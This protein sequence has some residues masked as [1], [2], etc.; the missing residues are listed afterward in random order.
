MAQYGRRGS[1]SRSVSAPALRVN[2]GSYSRGRSRES[3]VDYEK[4]KD[5]VSH[6]IGAWSFQEVGLCSRCRDNRE[7]EIL[8]LLSMICVSDL[9]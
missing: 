3:E 9:I 4:G 7:K 1:R 6:W 8:S 5:R 2:C